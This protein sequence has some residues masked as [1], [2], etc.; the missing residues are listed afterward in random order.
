[1]RPPLRQHVHL[2]A[3]GEAHPKPLQRL[4]EQRPLASL[5]GKEEEGH[6]R[7]EDV[8]QRRVEA[9]EGEVVAAVWGIGRP[10]GLIE[11][12]LDSGGDPGVASFAG[13]PVIEHAVAKG[14]EVPPHQQGEHPFDGREILVGLDDC[15]Q[16]VSAGGEMREMI[17]RGC[18]DEV[19]VAIDLLATAFRDHR[20]KGGGGLLEGGARLCGVAAEFTEAE[21]EPEKGVAVGMQIVAE[22]W[23]EGRRVWRKRAVAPDDRSCLAARDEPSAKACGGRF[24]DIGRDCLRGCWHWRSLD[25]RPLR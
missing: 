3:N 17:A 5:Q 25:H 24:F 6:G 16:G 22:P 10:F 15:E 11:V 4:I 9:V 20:L 21:P 12:G 7:Q 18:H 8:G 2:A 1:M 14:A 13:S 19:E 23:C